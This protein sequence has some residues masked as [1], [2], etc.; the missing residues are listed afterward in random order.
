MPGILDSGN[1]VSNT[2]KREALVHF[3]LYRLLRNVLDGGRFQ[4][5]CPVHVEPERYVKSGSADLVLEFELDGRRELVVIEVKGRTRGLA[6]YDGKAEDQARAYAEH[7]SSKYYAVTDGQILR[8]FKLSGE[9]IGDYEFRLEEKFVGKFLDELYKLI[10]GKSERLD[11]PKAPSKDEVTKITN[12]VAEAIVEV[13]EELGKEKGFGLES[14]MKTK[15][16]MHYLS[17]GDLKR[18]FR[19]GTPPQGVSGLPGVEIWLKT[20]R[21]K[22]DEAIIKKLMDDLS[23]IP[24]FKWAKN[25]SP[26]KE[27]IYKN[28]FIDSELDI[29]DFKAKLKEWLVNMYKLTKQQP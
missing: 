11:L 3:E 1:I 17:V 20:M 12:E 21:R 4:H 15:A 26:E 7:L 22:L 28:I 19:L 18:V 9:S 13:L 29:K 10:V 27:F 25:Y 16:L 8:L 2:M 6:V 14:E 5:S 24:G 23:K